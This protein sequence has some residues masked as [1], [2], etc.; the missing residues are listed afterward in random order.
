MRSTLGSNNGFQ[1]LLPLLIGVSIG[2]SAGDLLCLLDRRRF[3]LGSVHGPMR[4]GVVVADGGRFGGRGGLL[5][6]GSGM[7][8]GGLVIRSVGLGSAASWARQGK[9]GQA[10]EDQK[11]W[12]LQCRRQEVVVVAVVVVEV[13]ME[14]I[15]L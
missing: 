13:S 8:T 7:T 9:V 12:Q 10:T 15:V 4:R 1:L 11:G 5:C 3:D 6:A 2:S 14:D